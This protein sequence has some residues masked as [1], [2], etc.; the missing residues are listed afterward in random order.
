[1]NAA[2]VEPVAP[3]KPQKNHSIKKNIYC[4]SSQ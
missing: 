4:T 2:D 1:M 3:E